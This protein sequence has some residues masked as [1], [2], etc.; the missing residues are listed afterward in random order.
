MRLRHPAI[1]L[2]AAMIAAVNVLALAACAPVQKVVD[3]PKDSDLVE[4][5]VGQPLRVRLTNEIERQWR[6]D[7]AGSRTVQL[8]SQTSQPANGGA[9]SLAHFD[10]VAT[11]PG[12][13]N[14]KFTLRSSG[15]APAAVNET[16]TISVA[17]E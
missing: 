7:S 11:A 8:V 2:T 17:V 4:L 10:F 3:N 15:V 16:L 14:L 1:F 9:L 5:S 13:E 12:E 6:W